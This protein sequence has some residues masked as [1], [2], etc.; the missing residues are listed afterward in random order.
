MGVAVCAGSELVTNATGVFRAAELLYSGAR[1]EQEAHRTAAAAIKSRLVPSR[2]MS[3]TFPGIIRIIQLGYYIS[4]YDSV[5]P[6]KG[7]FTPL[8]IR[9]GMKV[10]RSLE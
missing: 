5:N 10:G 4:I 3:F 9:S 1:T 2:I 6:G 7:I 8:L